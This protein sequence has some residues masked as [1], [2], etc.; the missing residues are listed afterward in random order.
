MSKTWL[1]FFITLLFSELAFA[2]RT[3]NSATVDGASN[4]SVAASATISLELEVTTDGNGGNNDWK[5]TGWRIA[6]AS[7][8]FTCEDHADVTSSST[9]SQTFNITAPNSDDTYNLY[10]KAYKNDSCTGSA[11][12]EFELTNAVIVGGGGGASELLCSSQTNNAAINEIQTQDNFIEIYLKNSADILNWALYVDNTKVATLGLGNCEINGTA[13]TDNT[14]SGGTNSIFPSGTFITCDYNLNPS[15]SEVLLVDTNGSFVNG[16]NVVIDY[17]GYG[18]LTPSAI[19]DVNAICG[20]LYPGHNAN[21][22]DIARIPDGTGALVDNGNNST[23]GT[24]NALPSNAIDH[25]EIYHDGS[26]ITCLS[27]DINIKACTNTDC[28][29]VA[30]EDIT[31]TLNLGPLGQ[32]V[33]INNGDITSNVNYTTAGT[34]AISLSNLST[35]APVNCFVNNIADLDCEMTFSESGFVID[36][37]TLTACKPNATATIRAVQ[38]DNDTNTCGAALIGNQTVNFWSSYISPDSGTNDVLINTIA[39]ADSTPGTGVSLSFDI[40]GLATFTVQYDDAGQLQLNAEHTMLSGLLLEGESTFISKPLLLTVYTDETD[41]DCTSGDA[42]C[43]RFIKA[44]ENFDLKVKAACWVDDADTDFTDNP[45]TPNFEMNSIAVLSSV[46]AP[47]GGSNGSLDVTSFNFSTSDNG[48]HTIDQA[49]SEVG[50]FNFAISPS[51]YFGESLTT[52]NSPNIG[53][54]YPDHLEA[55]I[56]QGEFDN[57]RCND[58]FTFAGQPFYYTTTP[59]IIVTAYNAADTK[60]ITTNYTGDFA[61]SVF[62]NFTEPSPTTDANAVRA[63]GNFVQFTRTIAGHTETDHGDG[64]HT[65]LFGNDTYVYDKTGA[66]KTDKFINEIHFDFPVLT[67]NDGTQT[68][69]VDENDALSADLISLKP[70]GEPIRFGRLSIANVHGSELM[71]LEVPIQSEYYNGNNWQINTLDEC[72]SLNMSPDFQ[73]SNPETNNGSLQA[74]TATMIID[75][76]TT[77]AALTNNSPLVNGVATMTFSAPGED[78]QGY[79]DIQSQTS[80]NFSWLLGDYDNDGVYDDEATGRAS[81]GVFKGSDNIIFRRENF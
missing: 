49:I 70:S 78:N 45:A 43:S 17:L 39:I 52:Q 63:D 77:S 15:N 6:T 29:S 31:S 18:N 75:G 53:R 59:Q 68:F 8:G 26:G 56:E 41:Y 14:G 80:L 25:Y 19:W 9:T 36:V 12:T 54:F 57:T 50:V 21:N 5:S 74:G 2:G 71:P 34:I 66:N 79:V 51:N 72:T 37:P 20:S 28:S 44:G 67:D 62:L 38:S 55:T 16:D 10:L 30:S 24:G 81:F 58:A 33:T 35:S 1:L 65:Y 40:D 73:L 13:A 69:I 46:V 11:S 76:G 61:Q 64:S 23:K 32:A 22:K 27:E 4:T 60:A 47:S 42:S 48:I 7:G 3:I